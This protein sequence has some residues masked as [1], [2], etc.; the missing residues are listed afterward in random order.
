ME[1]KKNKKAGPPTSAMKQQLE[2]VKR[3]AEEAKLKSLELA[4]EKA[5]GMAVEGRNALAAAATTT[6]WKNKRSAKARDARAKA[7]GR[8]PN[9]TVVTFQWGGA[10]WNGDMRLF[11]RFGQS[12]GHFMHASDGLF[13]CAEELDVMFWEWFTTA[14]TEGE[15]R[16][17]VF[18]P[19]PPAPAPWPNPEAA[20][21]TAPASG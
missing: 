16:L 20:A 17:L 4:V 9:A 18:A 12:V 2:R 10:A 15:K 21:G 8:L 11:G 13:R 19:D 6:S 5:R 14:A 1:E 7:R 3:I